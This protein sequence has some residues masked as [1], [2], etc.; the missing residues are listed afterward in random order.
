MTHDGYHAGEV[1]LLLG[2]HGRQ[3][4][5]IWHNVVAQAPLSGQR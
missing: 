5:D 1:S 2:M 4:A 3:V